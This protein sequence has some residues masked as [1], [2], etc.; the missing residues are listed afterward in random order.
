MM[1]PLEWD[2]GHRIQTPPTTRLLLVD[3]GAPSWYW[4]TFD[5]VTLAEWREGR[6]AEV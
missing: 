2:D 1:Q 3:K 6:H 5:G 4:N